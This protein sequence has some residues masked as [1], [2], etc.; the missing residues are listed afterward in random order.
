M[1]SKFSSLIL[2]S[3]FG[4]NLLGLT[5]KIN[6][7]LFQLSQSFLIPLSIVAVFL[8]GLV[9][10]K[11]T[12]VS[13]FTFSFSRTST[14][15]F[16]MLRVL[17]LSVAKTFGLLITRAPYFWATFAISLSSVET[18]IRFFKYFDFLA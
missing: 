12:T 7:Y 10:C 13:N 11:R 18:K 8:K 16:K 2:K 6:L 4:G 5:D 17:T 3:Q 1:N 15:C 9:V 14:V